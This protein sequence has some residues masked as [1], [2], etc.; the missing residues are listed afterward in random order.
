[1]GRKAS[2]LRHRTAPAMFARWGISAA[3]TLLAVVESAHFPNLF[4]DPNPREGITTVVCTVVDKSGKSKG[5]IRITINPEWSPAGVDRF[6]AMVEDKFFTDHPLYRAVP[7]FLVQ[8]G[9]SGKAS[10]NQKWSLRGNIDDDPDKQLAFKPGVLSFAGGGPKTRGTA[11]FLALS[12]SPHQLKAFGTQLWET[13]LGYVTQGLDVLNKIYTGYGDMKEQGG[14]G[15]SQRELNS[16]GN[17]ALANFP[18]L[19][20]FKKCVQTDATEAEKKMV[21]ISTW[22]KV[23]REVKRR[24]AKDER[25]PVKL[26]NNSD[27]KIDLY[28]HDGTSKNDHLQG[29]IKPGEHVQQTTFAGHIF[30]WMEHASMKVLH[31]THIDEKISDYEFRSDL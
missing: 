6:K 14:R 1:M 23:K 9:A 30:K 5:D 17:Q 18:R 28:W 16:R 3:L 31:Q 7:N 4:S 29:T 11:V 2:E 13:P 8:F 12:K 26:K 15:P 21:D 10:M 27:K 25:I 22:P 20:Y 19:D 24:Q